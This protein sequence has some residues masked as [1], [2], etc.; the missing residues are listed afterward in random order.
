MAGPETLDMRGGEVQERLS[1]SAIF[2]GHMF[3]LH[4]PLVPLL[5]IDLLLSNDN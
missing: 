4:V 5:V 1:F 3:R 2:T